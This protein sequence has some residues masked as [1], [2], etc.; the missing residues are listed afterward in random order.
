MYVTRIVEV[1]SYNAVP[2]CYNEIHF[3][4]L[5]RYSS[6]EEICAFRLCLLHLCSTV[7]LASF[8]RPIAAVD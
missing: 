2:I 7:T 1:Q 5:C 6:I 4:E 3:Q 8:G